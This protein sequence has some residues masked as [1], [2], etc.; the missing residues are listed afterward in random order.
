MSLFLQDNRESERKKHPGIC[1]HSFV[2][3]HPDRLAYL[4]IAGFSAA[5]ISHYK[6]CYTTGILALLTK[7]YV[8]ATKF[9]LTQQYQAKE[10]AIDGFLLSR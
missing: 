10:Q 3:S 7:K 6:V 8:Y 4:D 9:L 1:I 2:L 5:I